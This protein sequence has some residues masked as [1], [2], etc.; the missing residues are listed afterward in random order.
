MKK[1]TARTVNPIV[2]D[3]EKPQDKE[4]RNADCPIKTNNSATRDKMV[5]RKY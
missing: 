1:R 3:R 2:I 5:N 4:L